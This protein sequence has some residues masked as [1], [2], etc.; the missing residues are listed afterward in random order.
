MGAAATAAW[1]SDA[2]PPPQPHAKLARRGMGMNMEKK[3]EAHQIMHSACVLSYRGARRAP[4]CRG[5]ASLLAQQ[6]E[7]HPAGLN[8]VSS[9]PSIRSTT[10]A[11]APPPPA[12]Q[13]RGPS[14][15]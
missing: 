4:A 5:G 10:M 9:S 14:R 2:Q 12:A 3:G 11:E 1:G 15:D 6:K 8:H 13:R 7:R